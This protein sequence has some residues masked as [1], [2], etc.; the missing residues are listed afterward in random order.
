MH[1]RTRKCLVLSED[2]KAKSNQPQ[3]KQIAHK[4][5]LHPATQ[6]HPKAKCQYTATVQM[7]L[8]AHKKHPLHQLM[9]GVWI[10]N[11]QDRLF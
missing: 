1:P 6:Q 7:I 4:A 10:I 5:C 3:A 8:P 2:A 11:R 9:Q